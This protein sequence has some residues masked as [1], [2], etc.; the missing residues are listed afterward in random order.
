[1]NRV[2]LV[3]G[4]V[5]IWVMAVGS[6]QEVC[7]PCVDPPRERALVPEVGPL[8]RPADVPREPVPMVTPERLLRLPPED[9]VRLIS[10]VLEM[11]GETEMLEQLL[12]QAPAD[13][14]RQLL[15][16][17]GVPAEP[18]DGDNATGDGSADQASEDAEPANQ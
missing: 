8:L 2:S 17:W 13:A 6:A 5:M 15:A 12:A 4:W 16:S 11:R 10:T 18:Q 14:V 3:G 1:M 9:A 7:D